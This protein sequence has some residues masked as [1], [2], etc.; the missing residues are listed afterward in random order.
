[1]N[2]QSQ[3]IPALPDLTHPQELLQFG[4][5]LLIV[6]LIF[7]ILA[8]LLGVAIALLN[9]SLGQ[10]T[11]APWS[12]TWVNQYG[13]LL[14]VIQHTTLILVILVSGFFLCSTLANRYHHWE[15]DQIATVAGTVAGDRLE[16]STPQLRYT[17]EEPY[18]VTTVVNGQVV[19]TQ[20]TQEV[21]RYLTPSQTQVDV[22]L[23]QTTD[24]A[25]DRLLYQAQ[26]AAT[27]SVTNSLDVTED[28][29]FEAPPPVGYTLLQDYR[30][31]RNGQ[32]LQPSLQGNYSF[33]VR[34]AP[35]ESAQFRITY[36]ALGGP[37]WVYSAGG[38]LLSN[39]RLTAFANFRG[40]DFASGIVPTEVRPEGK[41]T[42]FTWVFA[43]NVSVLNPFGIFTAT[44]PVRNTGVLPRLLLLA[45]G[46]LLW[47]LLLLYLS[48]P[49]RLR[50]VA[51]ASGAFFGCLLSLTYLSRLLP[52]PFAWASLAPVL[53]VL[54]WGLGK[55]QRSAMAVA[56]AT[57][58]GA[59]LPVFGLLV[60]YSGLTLSLAGLLSVVWL[61]LRHWYQWQP[62]SLR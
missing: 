14:R 54:G 43:D 52:A 40:A 60:P 47:W 51:I 31:E 19:E 61:S 29:F 34:L 15:Q 42:R 55:H 13:S 58:S 22:T 39:F 21:S 33:P 57:I 4:E 3:G 48:V 7:V 2:P 9:F 17:V 35:T 23:N 32:R 59:I 8:G 26:F 37:R 16:Q 50:D 5:R 24:P 44:Q 12:L 53:L 36:Q 38:Q 46:I 18:T 27:Y 25:T 28:F 1:M 10:Q 56:I 49:L 30:V 41:G 45:P 6:F 11:K 62:R 20:R